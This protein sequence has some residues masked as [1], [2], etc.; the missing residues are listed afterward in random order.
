MSQSETSQNYIERKDI[1]MQTI[2]SKKQIKLL[3]YHYIYFQHF[4]ET[5][6]KRYPR[7]KR[8]IKHYGLHPQIAW[9][10]D[11]SILLLAWL[12]VKES[13]HQELAD[14]ITH[15]LN[16]D[17]K[18]YSDNL[19]EI[20]DKNMEDVKNF[21]LKLSELNNFQFMSWFFCHTDSI[22]KIY[23][24][25]TR[26]VIDLKFHQFEVDTPDFKIKG[27][28]E[29]ALNWLLERIQII[30]KYNYRPEDIRKFFLVWA[31]VHPMFWW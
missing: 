26:K 6:T 7:I 18:T 15:V 13:E 14:E 21:Y 22:L 9:D 24:Y 16:N 4:I 27:S 19:L 31:E 11:K 30:I 10:A 20:E 3:N 29:F 17:N 23:K 8:Q 28:Q 2:L 5:E 1:Q 25:D 12:S